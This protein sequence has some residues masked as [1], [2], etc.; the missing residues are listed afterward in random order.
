MFGV[1]VPIGVLCREPLIGMFVSCKNQ[2]GVS[3]VKVQP[4]LFQLTMQRVPSEKAAT[5]Q[6][7]MTV[8]NDASVR[9]IRKVRL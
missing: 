9:M 4:Q 7:V 5:E 1:G 2:V 6:R 8:R 3:G